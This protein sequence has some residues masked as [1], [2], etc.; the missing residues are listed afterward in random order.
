MRFLGIEMIN[1]VITSI[2][3]AEKEAKKIV[4]EANISAR[5]IIS[6]ADEKAKAVANE[7]RITAKNTRIESSAKASA[8]ADAAYAEIIAKAK[9]DAEETKRRLGNN[10]D[11]AVDFI[12]EGII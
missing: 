6:S 7:A 3:E 8:T 4:K 11:K 2:L 1:E 10:V 9:E 12:T 5:E